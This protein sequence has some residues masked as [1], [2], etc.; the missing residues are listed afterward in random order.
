MQTDTQTEV[1]AAFIEIDIDLSL[2]MHR[3]RTVETFVHVSIVSCGFQ[4]KCLC[5]LM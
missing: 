4:T 1:H 5:M 3:Y 2:E